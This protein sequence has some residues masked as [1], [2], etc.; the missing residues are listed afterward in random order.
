MNLNRILAALLLVGALGLAPRPVPSGPPPIAI[1]INGVVLPLQP[2]PVVRRDLLYVPVRRTIEALGLAFERRGR[3]ISTEVGAQTVSLTMGSRVAHVDGR[4]VLLDAAPFEIHDVLYAP[5]RFFTDVLGAQA[6]F[7][8]KTRTVTI[9][10]QLV[11]RASSGIAQDGSG[12]ERFGTVTAVDVDSDPP[13][14]TL[15]VNASVRTIS[16]SRNALVEMHDVDANVTVPGELADIRPGDFARVFTSKAGHVTRVVDAFGSHNGA[17]AAVA[18]DRFVLADG[19]VIV[20]SR[21]TQISLN[22]VPAQIGDLQ[23]GDRVTVRYN[24]ETNEVRSILVSR[25]VA[26]ASPSDGGPR[27]ASVTLGAD[28][29]LRAR[30]RVRVTLRGTPGGAA[31]FDIGPYVRNIAMS[32]GADGVYAGSYTL[33]NGV[34]FTDVPIIGHLRVGAADAPDAQAPTMLSAASSPPGIA[35][36]APSAGAVVNSDRPAIY[37]TF[38][39]DAVPVNPSSI[40]LRVNGHDVTA[41]C[42]RTASYI[43]YMPAHA[44]RNG[45]VK[46]VVRVADRAGNVTT[47]S[48]SF[49]IRTR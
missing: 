20:P 29:P 28:H 22:G 14:L 34:N 31:T 16:I 15:S 37:A 21:T 42:V 35:D 39:A 18:G 9:V 48:W 45:P 36:F 27:I 5:L 13:T 2:P 7:D 25:S 41:E 19:H 4:P 8:R 44:Y 38:V 49:T 23:V 26:Q 30:D 33:P 40:M 12:V 24:V 47:R 1:V 3:L 32:G 10:A 46:V 11:G 6:R 17:I 43:Q